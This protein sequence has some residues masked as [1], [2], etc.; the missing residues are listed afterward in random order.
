MSKSSISALIISS[1]LAASSLSYAE[2]QASTEQSPSP[3][4]STTTDAQNDNSTPASSKPN[5]NEKDLWATKAWFGIQMLPDYSDD[6]E[7]RGLRTSKPYVAF[8]SV[9]RWYDDNDKK[10]D[11]TGEK[12]DER[13]FGFDIVMMG[14]G[15]IKDDGSIPNLPSKFN[16][17]SRSLDVSFYCDWAP[18]SFVF[19]PGSSLAIEFPRLGFVS[20]DKKD[21][22]GNMVSKYARTGIVY[23][24]FNEFDPIDRLIGISRAKDGLKYPRGPQSEAEP[25]ITAQFAY[26]WYEEYAARHNANRFI[27]D[28]D[29]RI[30]KSLPWHFGVNVN[31]GSGPDDYSVRLAAVTP[32]DNVLK[33]FGLGKDASQSTETE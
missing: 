21:S 6:G 22:D 2:D 15:A 26:G 9:A 3:T 32:I 30:T 29:V 8:R 7:N 31:S 28:I 23:R 19:Y 1:L 11:N 25:A 5:N 10:I 4:D 27:T 20:R 24:Y 12:G 14:A 13:T 33:L 18:S 16:D 17:V